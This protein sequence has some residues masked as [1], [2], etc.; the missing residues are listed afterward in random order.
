MDTINFNLWLYADKNFTYYGY[1][2]D[3]KNVVTTVYSLNSNTEYKIDN[4]S[5]TIV[6]IIRADDYGKTFTG[7]TKLCKGD[8]YDLN[9]GMEIA[10]LKATIKLKK[11]EYKYSTDMVNTL[12]DK[13]QNLKTLMT[14]SVNLQINSMERIELINDRLEKLMERHD[15]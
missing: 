11:Y 4:A 13:I 3:G 10:R 1:L 5:K 12:N 15:K 2:C 9:K 8:E 6:C 7:K 14:D